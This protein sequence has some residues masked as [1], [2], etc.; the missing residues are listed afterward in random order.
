MRGCAQIQLGHPLKNTSIQV[1]TSLVV[2]VSL[3]IQNNLLLDIQLSF[4]TNAPDLCVGFFHIGDVQSSLGL[5]TTFHT[6][7]HQSAG[8]R[9]TGNNR[10]HEFPN[11]SKV[12]F[13]H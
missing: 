8:R 5:K 10:R 4:L 1:V 12:A 11:I 7:I 6:H 2:L 9:T 3:L 13:A